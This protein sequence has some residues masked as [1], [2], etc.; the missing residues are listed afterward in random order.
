MCFKSGRPSM[1]LSV[2]PPDLLMVQLETLISSVGSMLPWKDR[3][4]DV[5]FLQVLLLSE[6]LGSFVSIR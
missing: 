3:F 1:V 6:E 5:S 2:S 4:C